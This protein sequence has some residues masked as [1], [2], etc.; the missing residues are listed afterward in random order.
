MGE[1]REMAKKGVRRFYGLGSLALSA[2]SAFLDFS[3]FS[4][5]VSCGAPSGDEVLRVP[6][7]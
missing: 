6:M 4:I 1:K 7:T 3:G 2:A 5:F